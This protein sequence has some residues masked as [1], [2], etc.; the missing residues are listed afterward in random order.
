M[1]GVALIVSLTILLGLLSTP[2]DAYRLVQAAFGQGGSTSGT[3]SA[4]Y[5]VRHIV[6]Q[7]CGGTVH[8][9]THRALLGFYGCHAY[10]SGAQGV[11]LKD[12]ALQTHLY[13][14]YPNPI[15]DRARVRFD[16]AGGE[17]IHLGIYDVTGRLVRTM[18][19]GEVSSRRYALTWDG[20][21][22]AGQLLM[23]G[24]YFLRLDA[25]PQ[26]MCHRMLLIR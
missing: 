16:L 1:R 5:Q 18:L 6:G 22:G 26:S 3:A 12:A 24:V 20:R 25:S 19:S 15:H 17:Q 2:A 9:I 11:L 23:G 14:V 7:S 8:S 21:D 13:P 4:S 10:G